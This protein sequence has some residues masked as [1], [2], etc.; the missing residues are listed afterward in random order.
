MDAA[1]IFLACTGTIL[2]FIFICHSVDWARKARRDL[3]FL[4]G[5]VAELET[6][7]R[8]RTQER[9]ALRERGRDFH[10]WLR[11]MRWSKRRSFRGMREA[12]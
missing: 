9:D 5:R 10:A 3:R 8:E 6:T 11:A 1:I 12:C 2:A 4:R 7:V